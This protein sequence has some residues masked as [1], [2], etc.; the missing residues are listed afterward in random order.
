MR[1]AGACTAPPW[2]L[3]L[4]G[5]YRGA[6]YY[7]P[8]M[9]SISVGQ[10]YRDLRIGMFWQSGQEWIV[11]ALHVGADAIE[12][13]QLMSASDVSQRKALAVSVLFDATWYGC[14]DG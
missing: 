1:V 2:S 13:A 8:A 10:R 6:M 7:G 9:I 4:T 11:A 12:Y 3:F 5:S 14:V